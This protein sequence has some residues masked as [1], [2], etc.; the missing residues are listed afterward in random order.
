MRDKLA[1]EAWFVPKNET[2]DKWQEMRVF[3]AVVDAGSFA[4]AADEL[5]M[6]KAAVSR[7]VSELE[8]RLGVRLLH[9]TTRKLSLTEEGEVFHARCHDILATIEDSETEVATRAGKATGVLKISVPLSFGMKHLS[10]LWPKFMAA[11]PEVSLDVSLS[12]RVVDLF[13]EGLDLAIRIARLPDSS[14]VSR[15][16][17]TTRLILCA[18][19][20]Y[21]RRRGTPRKPADLEN[22][23][24]LNYTLLSMGE[25]WEFERAGERVTVRVH[26]RMRS[27]N[28]DTCLAA[29][30]SGAG[31]VLQPTF[32]VGEH[33]AAGRLVELLPE[34]RSIELGIFAVYP[35]R[36][37]VLPK[38]RLLI[39]F[40]STALTKALGGVAH[41]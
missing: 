21:I 13:D 39:D 35:T 7:H 14:L 1:S 23:E 2:M 25:Q 10:P 24:T 18:S 20:A 37:F 6:S 41:K 15:K 8:H 31:M 28:G 27:N 19:P 9:R 32:L 11:H 3:A 33:L 12:D 4:R 34:Y 36:K 40:L 38:V 22:H 16:L 26:S 17:A 29:A 30:I 5:S